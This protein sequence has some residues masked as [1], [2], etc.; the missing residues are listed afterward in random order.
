MK[1]TIDMVI[2][3]AWV[4]WLA[5]TPL[6]AGFFLAAWAFSG[7][8]MSSKDGLGLCGHILIVTVGALYLTVSNRFRVA[9]ETSQ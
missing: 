3:Y 9:K 8:P 7:A 5:C 4:V 6:I 1:D 2:F